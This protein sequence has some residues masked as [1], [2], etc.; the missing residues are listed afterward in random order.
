M[1]GFEKEVGHKDV[2]GMLSWT[3][4][5]RGWSGPLSMV[6]AEQTGSQT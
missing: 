3:V 6:L 2:S 5:M 1:L 4:M